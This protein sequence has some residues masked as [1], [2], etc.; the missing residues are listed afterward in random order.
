[1]HQWQQQWDEVNQQWADRTGDAEIQGRE[2]L[3]ID[4]ELVV[5]AEHSDR[6]QVRARLGRASFGAK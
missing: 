5:R 3:R 1:M 2:R 4:L 6:D